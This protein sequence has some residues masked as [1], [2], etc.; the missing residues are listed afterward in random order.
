MTVRKHYSLK[1]RNEVLDKIVNQRHS[2]KSV[3]A[4]FNIP[5]NTVM[6]WFR[7]ERDTFS[8]PSS[9]NNIPG[10][11]HHI[12]GYQD[13]SSNELTDIKHQIKAMHFEL[14]VLTNQNQELLE[15]LRTIIATD[16]NIYL[17]DCK[18]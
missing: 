3:S 4:E 18:N 15:M 17:V 10:T 12:F 7:S 6:R 5:Y 2:G 8:Q 11:Y 9:T 1:T 16:K 14:Q 13:V